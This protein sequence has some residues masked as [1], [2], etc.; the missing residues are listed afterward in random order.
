MGIFS[1][2]IAQR[3]RHDCGDDCD[4]QFRQHVLDS[5]R[6]I[7]LQLQE[8]RRELEHRRQARSATLTFTDSQGDIIMGAAVTVHINDPAGS[9]AFTEFDGPGGTGNKVPAIGP[10]IFSSDNVAVCAVDQG[11]GK[12]TYVGAGTCTITATDQGNG[13]S[14]AIAF[15]VT[16]AVAQSG[17]LTFIPPGIAQKPVG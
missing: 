14:D 15:T 2:F 6:L 9:F 11:S 10:V 5:L 12:P 8:I 13:I 3:H 1:E 7:E 4:R 17:V 16:A